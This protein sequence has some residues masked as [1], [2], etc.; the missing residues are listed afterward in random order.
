ML[1]NVMEFRFTKWL[2]SRVIVES[3]DVRIVG[4]EPREKM[5][6][7]LE[8]C[9]YIQRRFWYT[10]PIEQILTADEIEQWQAAR[11]P[12]L[13]APDGDSEYYADNGIINFY[14]QGFPEDKYEVLIQKIKTIL[15]DAGVKYGPFKKEN[16]Q[17]RYNTE[18]QRSQDDGEYE[19]E[20]HD[21]S[22]S[23]EDENYTKYTSTH[24]ERK[25]DIDAWYK[26]KNRDMRKTRV[27]RIPILQIPK[28]NVNE[29]PEVNMANSNAVLIFRDILKFEPTHDQNA[30]GSPDPFADAGTEFGNIDAWQV[31]QRIDQALRGGS[32]D[33]H[34][35][36][37]YTKQQPGNATIHHGGYDASSIKRRLEQIRQIAQWAVDNGYSQLVV[38]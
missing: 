7:L 29:P 14:Y 8:L 26:E 16:W 25:K 18:I 21:G 19:S 10:P 1:N 28:A 38:F 2:E 37:P 32:I 17:D 4:Y 36:D 15:D 23:Y 13:F 22:D 27:I 11:S 5:D 24:D 6:D 30:D 33:I 12:E 20:K 31:L 3:K 34:Q 35:R 9:F